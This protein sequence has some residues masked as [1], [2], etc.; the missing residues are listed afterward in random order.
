MKINTKSTTREQ[1][2]NNK[3]TRNQQQEN[4]KSTKREQE[5][6]NKR[7]GSSIQN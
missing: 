2:I 4:K 1:E 5:I 3:R 6:N 7:A